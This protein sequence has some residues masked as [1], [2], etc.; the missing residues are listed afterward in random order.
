MKCLSHEQLTQRVLGM[1]IDARLNAHIDGCADCQ[2]RLAHLES[3]ADQLSAAHE[4]YDRGHNVARARLLASLPTVK[5][6]SRPVRTGQT[7][8]FWF[9]ELNMKQRF[10]L[11]GMSVAVLLG[12]CVLLLNPSSQSVSAMELMRANLAK[13]K[14]YKMKM[15]QEVSFVRKPGEA[16]SKSTMTGAWYWKAPGSVRM[17]MKATDPKSGM[18]NTNLHP[19]GK[20]GIQIDHKTKTFTRSAARRGHMSPIM[21][22][23]GLKKYTGK[24]DKELGAKTINGKKVLGYV[25]DTKKI[26]PN[27]ERFGPT[28]LWIDAETHLPVELK[29]KMNSPVTPVTLSFVDFKWDAKFDAKLFDITPPKGYVDATPEPRSPAEM[30]KSMAAALKLY[31]ELSGGHYQRVKIVYGES[32]RDDMVEMAG[33]KG[34]PLSKMVTNETYEKI[35]DVSRGTATISMV[36]RDNEDAAYYGLTVGPKDKDKVLLRW[37]TGDNSYYVIYGNLRDESVTPGRLRALEGR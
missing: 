37:K 19:F 5:E 36:L 32:I 11:S 27:A 8:L 34:Q 30:A 10:A 15:I 31:A 13:A 9:G 28:E 33:L 35:M 12:L 6:K 18:N 24:A 1:E 25:I 17:D 16:P 2:A 23:E 22:L 7:I 26:D 4:Q 29:L 3:F 20:P 14:S 21:M